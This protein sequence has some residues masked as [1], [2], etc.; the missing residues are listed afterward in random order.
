MEGNCSCLYMYLIMLCCTLQHDTFIAF[1]TGF[2]MFWWLS[3]LWESR[4]SRITSSG[5]L[6][7]NWSRSLRNTDWWIS[8]TCSEVSG[9]GTV[10]LMVSAHRCV[11]IKHWFTWNRIMYLLRWFRLKQIYCW[12][13]YF[14]KGRLSWH[15][16]SGVGMIFFFFMV[17]GYCLFSQKIYRNYELNRSNWIGPF[18]AVHNFKTM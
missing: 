17:T 14:F 16:Y 6:V 7:S 2:T 5:T 11:G 18:C 8:S 13:V 9:V 1:L 10:W 4:Q 3:R 12:D 15:I